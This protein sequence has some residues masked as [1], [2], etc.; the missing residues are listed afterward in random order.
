LVVVP[1]APTNSGEIVAAEDPLPHQVV[2]G[3]GQGKQALK[4]RPG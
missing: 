1:A 4:L 3:R 2:F